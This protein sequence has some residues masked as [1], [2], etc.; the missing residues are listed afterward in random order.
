MT[1]RIRYQYDDLQDVSRRFRELT[2][3][4]EQLLRRSNYCVQ[5]LDD[6]VWIGKGADKYRQE[7]EN[8]ILPALR[9]LSA[10]LGDTA[11]TL[12]KAG[13]MMREA[14]EIGSRLFNGEGGGSRGVHFDSIGIGGSTIGN[15]AGG[16][17]SSAELE[18]LAEYFRGLGRGRGDDFRNINNI[19]DASLDLRFST[20]W[21]D[22][23]RGMLDDLGNL[24]FGPQSPD[25]PPTLPGANGPVVTPPWFT[26]HNTDDGG[27]N[28]AANS[29]IMVAGAGDHERLVSDIAKTSGAMGGG[30]VSGIF[31][32]E[33]DIVRGP[34]GVAVA[35]PAVT[36]SHPAVLAMVEWLRAHP[37]GLFIMPPF[38]AHYGA[39]ALNILS[40][41]GFDLSGLNVVTFG[42][43]TPPDMPDGLHHRELNSLADLAV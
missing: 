38:S 25:V 35:N 1:D 6:G 12:T 24:G 31:A 9:R 11:W 42:G 15:G 22:R 13:D 41:E 20:R 37:D 3:R 16:R 39:E 36:A 33:E 2:D 28:G 10:L 27:L 43:S 4:A 18:R 7:M 14:E 5:R 23:I 40:A 26:E 32:T 30:Q 8:L 34:G 29:P 17:W 21:L 19:S